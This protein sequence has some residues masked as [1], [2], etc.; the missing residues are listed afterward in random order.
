MLEA[1]TLAEF[2]A[3]SISQIIDNLDGVVAQQDSFCLLTHAETP[4][5]WHKEHKVTAKLYKE[6]L[7][8]NVAR[9]RSG[10]SWM[11]I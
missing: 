11:T 1:S 6:P 5:T 3:D 8:N 4:S 2:P 7:F 10:R 9:F